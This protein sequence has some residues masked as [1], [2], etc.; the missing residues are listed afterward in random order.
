ML[1]VCPCRKEAQ[2]SDVDRKLPGISMVVFKKRCYL[3][4]T[5][6]A[7]ESPILAWMYLDALVCSLV[8][9]LCHSP[10][11]DLSWPYLTQAGFLLFGGPPALHACRQVQA[12]PACFI[13]NTQALD[14]RLVVS[15]VLHACCRLG[16]GIV[17]V[18]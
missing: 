5:F 17:L 12:R 14:L 10:S 4:V 7:P 11:V 8:L 3:E 9:A 6:S 2:V 15:P 13:P 18:F 16:L 1:G